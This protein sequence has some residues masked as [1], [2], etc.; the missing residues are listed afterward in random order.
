MTERVRLSSHKLSFQ[1]IAAALAQA[2]P[3]SSS[4][5]MLSVSDGLRAQARSNTAAE[6]NVRLHGGVLSVVRS[7]EISDENHALVVSLWS[8]WL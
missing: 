2:V 8:Y 4:L 3:N 5:L 6:K 7:P 1:W